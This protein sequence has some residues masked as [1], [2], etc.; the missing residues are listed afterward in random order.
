MHMQKNEIINLEIT[1][2]TADGNGVGHYDGMA[3]F[4]P[5]LITGDIATVKI[6]KVLKNYSFGIIDKI[7]KESE[8]RT[9]S[10]CPVSERCG[11][12]NFRFMK[13]EE[14]LRVK[15]KIVSDAFKRIGKCNLEI[16]TIV[17]CDE[18]N[19]YRNKAQYP[20]TMVN[21]EIKCGFFAKR[22]HR[23]VPCDDCYLQPKI[24]SDI[25]EHILKLLNTKRKLSVY[26]EESNTGILRHLYIRQGFH[27]NEIMICF[28]VR[29]NIKR[30]LG[31]I[32]KSLSEKFENIKSIV[33]NIN[34]QKTNVILGKE[35][36][37]LYGKEKITDIMC[38]IK[39]D[40]SPLS[41]YQVN[42]PQ[43]EKLYRIA[44]KYADPNKSKILLD[45]YCG[46]GTIGLSMA[47]SLKKL[48]GIEIIQDAV[49][50]AKEN[51]K[52]NNL[53][54]TEFI[55]SD[56]G[57]AA[58]KLLTSDISTDIITVDPPRKGCDNNMI[59]SLIEINPKK[60]VMIS[61]NP[62]T[63]ARDCLKL[64]ENGYIIDKIQPV[65][66]FPFTGHVE[67]VI[68]LSQLPDEHI[69]IDIDLNELDLTSAEC[70][71]TYPQI[72]AYVKEHT[73]L[74]V[75]SLYIAQIKEKCGMVKRINYNK[76]KS[77]NTR[78]PNCPPEKEQ[79]IL[80]A[81]RHFKMI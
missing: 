53:N 4:V 37:L 38:G 56:A 77:E 8:N 61:C 74:S 17:P 33:M 52:I 32:V 42:T 50:N 20:F 7:I 29:K 51:A 63:A 59:N 10:V 47:D 31:F 27:T 75:S 69:D 58:K 34:S 2:V 67:C 44:K 78:Q 39:V 5:N 64:S 11:G 21:G 16:E 18:I 54:N 36:V 14:Q 19:R 76:P 13:Y 71:A 66:L 12:C 65:D 46:T 28:V 73:G 30:E 48:I 26:N 25:T 60:I 72:K 23:V 80:D 62:A 15:Q 3:V 68:L 40:I 70:K 35:N 49:E 6:V 9:E 55:C 1:D 24:F 22:S 45:F 79:A 57:I 81:F 43:A 41:F